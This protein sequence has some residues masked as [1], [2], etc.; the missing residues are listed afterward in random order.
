MDIANSLRYRENDDSK[1]PLSFP[2]YLKEEAGDE[3]RSELGNISI[4]IRELK[5]HDHEIVFFTGLFWGPEHK[6][7]LA[8][9]LFSADPLYGWVHVSGEINW[10]KRTAQFVVV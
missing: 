8:Y 1:Q 4:R 9:D 3:S 7:L 6:S 10:E 2:C 5:R